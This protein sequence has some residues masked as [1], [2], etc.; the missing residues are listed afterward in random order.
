MLPFNQLP[1]EDAAARRNI[2]THL[3][4][5]EN[6]MISGPAYSDFETVEAMLK[7]GILEHPP[8]REEHEQDDE[9]V[10]RISLGRVY[11]RDALEKLGPLHVLWSNED[12]IYFLPEDGQ[13]SSFATK[14]F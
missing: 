2:L 4:E 6:R 11:H 12:R 10:Y 13:W 14:P 7:D 5:C 8:V 3:R 9:R 1:L